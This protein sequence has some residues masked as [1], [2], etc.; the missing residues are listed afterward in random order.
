MK[1]IKAHSCFQVVDYN[2]D[3]ILIEGFKMIVVD[4]YKKKAL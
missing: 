4:P 2:F 3:N 1:D